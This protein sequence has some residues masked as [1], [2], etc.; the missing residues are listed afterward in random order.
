M[1]FTYIESKDA[2]LDI[3]KTCIDYLVSDGLPDWDSI[4]SKNTDQQINFNVA[5]L[6][7]PFLDYA[8]KHWAYHALKCEKDDDDLF[9]LLDILLDSKA[10]IFA[11]YIEI[12]DPKTTVNKT[13]ALHIA[14]RSGLAFYT[15]HLLES[16][17]D[18][19]FQDR[20][21]RTPL[22]LAASNGFEEVVEEL[23]KHGAEKCKDE[24]AGYTPIHLAASANRKKVVRALLKAGV[25]PLEP[26]PHDHPG[27]VCKLPEPFLSLIGGLA[28]FPDSSHT[29]LLSN[30]NSKNLKWCGN[31]R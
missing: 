30:A 12:T 27:N 9:Q 19:N 14:A 2:H 11:A 28:R 15:K 17:H 21:K 3:A 13:S 16:G 7:H 24:Y 5:R 4:K 25:S 22:H 26:R 31:A 18:A 29:S 8:T 10:P 6:T 23:V 1:E 20:K